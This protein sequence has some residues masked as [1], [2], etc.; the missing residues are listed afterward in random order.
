[1]GAE[2]EVSSRS[3]GSKFRFERVWQS[4]GGGKDEAGIRRK[5]R[6]GFEQERDGRNGW[7]AVTFGGSTDVCDASG[8]ARA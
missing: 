8:I 4:G 7:G 5:L 6:L 1:M 3:F 2:G